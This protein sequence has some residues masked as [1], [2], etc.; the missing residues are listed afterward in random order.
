[1]RQIDGI[2]N[3]VCCEACCRRF[4]TKEEKLYVGYHRIPE[5]IATKRFGC[6]TQ[7]LIELNFTT[8]YYPVQKKERNLYLGAEAEWLGRDRIRAK[9]RMQRIAKRIQ[10]ER[11]LGVQ[12]RTL[13]PVLCAFM[14]GD[15][16]KYPNKSKVTLE[17]IKTLFAVYKRA[18][19]IKRSNPRSQPMAIFNFCIDYPNGTAA[20]FRNLK[21]KTCR[22]FEIVGGKILQKLERSELSV[23]QDTPLND[24]LDRLFTVERR[25]IIHS[26]S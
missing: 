19:K 3:K 22:V 16:L 15:Y 25:G 23:L 17:Q 11:A 13:D 5:E 8:V 6:T 21:S 20:D 14:I 24:V 9:Y 12:I 2:P 1:L 18:E 10:L 7:D 26:P 4:K